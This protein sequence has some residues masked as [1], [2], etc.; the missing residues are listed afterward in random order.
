MFFY[1]CLLVIYA[2]YII[3]KAGILSFQIYTVFIQD[4][5]ML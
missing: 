3:V 1:S 2:Y 4:E 5:G